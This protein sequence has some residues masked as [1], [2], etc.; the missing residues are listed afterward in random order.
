M[1]KIKKCHLCGINLKRKLKKTFYYEDGK[2]IFIIHWVYICPDCGEIVYSAKDYRR[3]A[4]KMQ[5]L[6]WINGS[7]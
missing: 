2:R 6:G 1:I 5:F 3:I 7:N 4:K